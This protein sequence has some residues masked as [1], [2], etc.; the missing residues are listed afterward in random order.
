MFKLDIKSLGCFSE[1]TLFEGLRNDLLRVSCKNKK[2]GQPKPIVVK[3]II[4]VDQEFFEGLG[5]YIGEGEKSN[6]PTR[7]SFT[8]SDLNLLKFFISWL[9]KYFGLDKA[10]LKFIVIG[11]KNSK[12]ININKRWAELL[13]L[14][15]DQFNRPGIPKTNPG[16]IERVNIRFHSVLFHRLVLT[17][18]EIALKRCLNDLKLGLGFVRGY[19]AAEGCPV[20]RRNRNNTL[21]A[22][23]LCGKDVRTLRLIRNILLKHNVKCKSP[24]K[25]NSGRNKDGQYEL[26][27]YGHANFLILKKLDIFKNSK[28]RDRVFRDCLSRFKRVG[29]PER[30]NGLGLGG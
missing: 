11:S 28:S 13:G 23:N 24:Q 4:T 26:D 25:C 14:S 7:I 30:S 22:V 19:Y 3:R 12:L 5:L 10:N 27:I 6:K 20:V 18:Q 9:K 2:G 15:T 29:V 8:N 21:N 17:M 1:N 16:N